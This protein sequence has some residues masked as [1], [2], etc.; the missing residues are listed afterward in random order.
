[1]TIYPARR[2]DAVDRL[3]PQRRADNP[4]FSMSL[5]DGRLTEHAHDVAPRTATQP[6]D[7]PSNVG[8]EHA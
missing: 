2:T 6:F 5:P 1:M 8:A 4:E 3:H 7:V